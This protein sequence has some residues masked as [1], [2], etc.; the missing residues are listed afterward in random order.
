MEHEFVVRWKDEKTDVAG[1]VSE[2]LDKMANSG[3]HYTYDSYN[4]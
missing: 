4:Y 2:V 1:Y 3:L